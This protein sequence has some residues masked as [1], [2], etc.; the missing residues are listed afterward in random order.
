GE[1]P[2][3]VAYTGMAIGPDKSSQARR[4]RRLKSRRIHGFEVKVAS[5]PVSRLLGLAL[6]DRHR[7]PEG[8][9]IPRCR[10][11]HTFGMR[12]PLDLLFLG[13]NCEPLIAVR[14]VGPGHRLRV[15]E[16]RAVLEL[17][18]DWD[19]EKWDDA[20]AADSAGEGD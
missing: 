17:P 2:V 13:E 6:L 14:E 18:S 15:P 12:F 11:V 20:I 7:A 9:L 1:F 5:D 4:F 19:V 10:S 3:P 16:A 8:L